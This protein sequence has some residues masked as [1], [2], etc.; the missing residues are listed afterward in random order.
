MNNE[1]SDFS[2]ENSNQTIEIGI[3]DTYSIE[4]N[5]DTIFTFNIPDT[6]ANKYQINIHSIN[7]NF[8]IDSSVDIL[9][10]IN[11]DTY[12]LEIN[13]DK[14]KIIVR[15]LIEY[16]NR[17]EKE[18]Y[19]KKKCHLSI[20]SINENLPGLRI[21]NKQESFFYFK[22]DNHNKLNIS[23][24]IKELSN[25]SFA[26]LFFRFN[27][28]SDFSIDIYGSNTIGQN[29]LI[30]KKIY[31]SSYIFLDSDILEN[32]D[33]DNE[34]INLSIIIK[35]ND[36]KNINMF[37]KMV[38]KEM[39]SMIQKNALNY[40]FITTEVTY[41]YFYLEVFNEEEGEVMLH[42]KRFYGELI[43]K[44]VT[45]DEI[46]NTNITDSS[47]YPQEN[48]TNSTNINYNPH[49][50]KLIYSYKDTLK[51]V[52]GCYILITYKQKKSEG[53]FPNIGYEFTL[54]SRSWNY[55]DYIPQIIDIPFNEFIL[56]AFEKRSINTHHYYSVVV[57]DEIETIIV[58]IEGNY[59]DCFLGEGRKRINT[60]NIRD[61]EI[62]L[63][64]INNQ[65]VKSFNLTELNF[66]NK[67]ISFA[68]RS[69][70]YFD[71]IF[72]FYYFRVLYVP[73]NEKLFL[74]VDSQLGNLCLPEHDEETNHYYCHLIYKNKYNELKANFTISS[75]NQNE[76]SKIYVTKIFKNGATNNETKDLL[77]KHYNDTDNDDI[78]CFLFTFEFQNSDIKSII[79]SFHESIKYVYL[80]I[81]SPQLFYIHSFN[82]S[83]LFNVRNN[84]ILTYKYI[85]GRNLRSGSIDVTFSNSKSFYS[86][87][88]F[89]GRLFI[90]DID[91]N[92][93][94]INY[95]MNE[96]EWIFVL[97]L[98]YNMRNKGIIEIKSGEARSQIIESGNFP[99]YYYLKIEVEDYIHLDV[100][101]RLNSFDD[102]VMKNKFD[103]N[104]YLV[105]ED[106]IKRKINEEYIQLPTAI[107]GYYSNM[108]KV[109]LLEINQRKIYDDNNYLL[110]EIMNNNTI[111]ISS[112]ILVDFIIKENNQDIYFMPI[113]Q[114]IIETFNDFNGTIRDKN[115]Y[116]LFINQKETS[117]IVLEISPLYNDL[118]V[119]FTNETSKSDFN[120]TIAYE[121]GF[122]RYVIYNTNDDMIYFYVVNPKKRKASYMIRY[123]YSDESWRHVYQ[124]NYNVDKQ[125]INQNNDYITLSLTF[126]PIHIY[127]LNE[128]LNS[129]NIIYLYINGILY[130]K[131]DSEELINTTAILYER[132]GL[133]E[134]QTISLYHFT[135]G[136]KY[137]LLFENIP[138]NNNY[139]YD[140]QIQMNSFLQENIF[141]ESYLIY[142]T[143]VDLTDIKLPGVEGSKLWYI[144]GPILGALILLLIIFF[145]VK[146]IRLQK[147]NVVLREDL[148]S[149]AYSNDIQKNV[150]NKERQVSEKDKDYD[151]T[152]I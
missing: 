139:V 39:V 133:K 31:N 77:Y 107:K 87:R 91:S 60:M 73:K 120:Y 142:S 93:N 117:Q 4:Y 85:N 34:S 141:T 102:S 149:L 143:E 112:S 71:N 152:F 136:E 54:L 105:N 128:P 3:S 138:R 114:Y 57:P 66:K 50:L 37:F 24:K 118:D 79:S 23:Y 30:S 21:D 145:V 104:G 48:D 92:K 111:N 144:L 32:V 127:Y 69:K 64:I 44:I 8:E 140:L 59:I 68:L 63:D 46:N 36:N 113:N 52:D 67:R 10:Q 131:Q 88:N 38:E 47:I 9:N 94:I 137:T 97:K 12:S 89:R 20:N 146:Y 62:N 65:N 96:G 78:D 84:Y 103:I 43:A 130:K 72:S 53:Y 148:K 151:S 27:E 16:T 2:A 122:K 100:N 101:L 51:C 123:H 33:K 5:K 99:L 58:Q 35:K 150:I 134:Y 42:N 25:D 116:Q 14:E 6:D 135:S 29:N 125:Y 28:N 90:F 74:P 26:A 13:K 22:S 121:K 19:E 95:H 45:K 108:Y 106:T 147:T 75:Y 82:K 49:N 7:C 110:I 119:I 18:N 76:Y 80:Q 109:G 17:E 83:C 61:N 98:E 70:D 115:N 124:F 41:Q 1:I 132:K 129:T 15:P 81:Y 56:G 40:G 126:D 11:L 86:N 55:S